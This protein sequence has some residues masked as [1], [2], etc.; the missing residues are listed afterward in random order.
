MPASPAP[1]TLGAV[2]SGTV[3]RG[4][5]APG[6]SVEAAAAW[7]ANEIVA[8]LATDRELG[9]TLEEARRRLE[10]HG[11]NRLRRAARP[12]YVRIAG[13]QL[14]DPLV[15]L[16]LAAAVVSAVIGERIEAAAIAA[17]VV[18]NGVL[19]FVQ[20]AGAERAVVALR[21]AVERTAAV[22]RSG[23][24]REVP[25]EELVPGD[26]VVVR[27]GDRVPADGRILRA[28]RLEVDE[29]ALTG[30]SV[31]VAKSDGAVGPRTPLAERASM[32]YAGTGVTRG[33]AHVVVTATGDGT[34]MGRI[35]GL[36]AAAK[37]PPTPLQHRLGR[38]SRAMVVLGIGLTVALGLGMLARGE[39]LEDAFLVAVA[40]AVAAVP[41][42]LAATVTIALAQ[43]ARAMA[44]RGAIVRRLSAVETLGGATL[45]ATDKTGTLTVNQLRLAR[46]EPFDARSADELL[47]AAVLASDAELVEDERGLRVAGD[48]VDGAFLLALA[49][50]GRPDPRTSSA[51][52]AVLEMPFDPWRK[53]LTAV[54]AEGDRHRVVVKGAPEIVIGRSLL[55]EARREEVLRRALALA[56]EGMRVLAVGQRTLPLGR[57]PADDDLD[58]DLELVGLVA[59]RD[60]LRPGARDAV[61]DARE[62]G[63]AV[64]MLTG[65]H[66]A[67][68]AAIAGSLQLGD[69]RTVTGAEL[70]EVTDDALAEAAERHSVFARVTPADKLRLVEACQASG[71]VV[72]V[73]GDGINDTPALRRA[74]VGVAMGRSGTE[75][76]REA[77]EIVLTD[78][79]FATI[80]AAIREG[81]RITDNIRKFV[82][83]LLSA[84]L[85]EVVLF[86]IAVLAG[87]GVPMTVVM[88]LT[89]NL[90]TD[91]LP[92]IAL[93][94]D[95]AAPGTM[96]PARRNDALFTR[97]HTL[98]L[99]LAGTSVGLAATGAYL[100]GR[101]L[102]PEA[103]QT[104]AF[105]TI[106]LAELLFV[107]SIRSPRAAAWRC[108]RNRVLD[109]SVLASAGLLALVVYL[110]L[111][112]EPFGTVALGPAELAVAGPLAA[113]P[114]VLVE[115]VKA[116]RR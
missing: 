103:A 75:A 84:N 59:L 54:Y 106:A 71:H 60:P 56:G 61:R 41:E 58:D 2:S 113:L 20:E 27:E 18:L 11:P 31:P 99:A 22:I 64:A 114:F 87:L 98:A 57:L 108:P 102:A 46:V 86:S 73:T 17:I 49:A 107:Y 14:A 79:D 7:P 88:V 66:P 69:G 29:S 94:R 116:F 110:P 5:V 104:M 6:P 45:I 16:L 9:L 93:A 97:E 36:T 80:V 92:A 37:P 111:L 3:E 51:R 48:P 90:L 95:P 33:R 96:R 44:R 38:L 13:R 25:V 82:A 89:V 68:A 53:R 78:D 4:V 112:R 24:E 26:V 12:R 47:D 28:E 19:G 76:A 10:E 77:A 109:A 67:T 115:A 30:E 63:I 85:G 105:A 50:S 21:D 100:V 32:V 55:S 40:V 15:G 72:A 34:E 35:A 42:G 83:F 39:P 65:D 8:L 91:G 23:R 70:E 1:C 74:D 43:G 81:R 62:A 52:R 101:E